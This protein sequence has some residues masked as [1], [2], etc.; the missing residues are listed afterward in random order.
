MDRVLPIYNL[1]YLVKSLIFG[2]FK[3]EQKNRN[4]IDSACVFIDEKEIE[5][6]TRSGNK[7]K[8]KRDFV[9]QRGDRQE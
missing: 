9:R 7:E 4:L 6:K 5:L 1:L 8:M 3:K 2:L